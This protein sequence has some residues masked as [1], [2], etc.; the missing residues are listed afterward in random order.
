[1]TFSF[2]SLPLPLYGNQSAKR[3]ILRLHLF[4]YLTESAWVLRMNN[5]VTVN[6]KGCGER[7]TFVGS[8]WKRSQHDSPWRYDKKKRA[9][10]AL[11][12]RQRRS[13]CWRSL[14]TP[15]DPSIVVRNDLYDVQRP[16]ITATRP[17]ND[18]KSATDTAAEG[19]GVLCLFFNFAK[20]IGM[21]YFEDGKRT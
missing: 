18:L 8:N 1:M 16:L 6:P 21:K 2:L 11:R 10:V 4:V 15:D 3:K 17:W 19:V 9:C 12:L 20:W 5:P 7:W 14:K 13:G